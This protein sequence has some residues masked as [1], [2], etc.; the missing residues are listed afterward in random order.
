[1]GGIV[2]DVY[3]HG[4]RTRAEGRDAVSW[5]KEAV[6]RNL[7][8]RNLPQAISAHKVDSHLE[9]HFLPADCLHSTVVLGPGVAGRPHNDPKIALKRIDDEG[10]FVETQTV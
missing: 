7:Q 6:E 2:Y 10:R 8:D 3:V 5:A 1:M 9:R 4:G